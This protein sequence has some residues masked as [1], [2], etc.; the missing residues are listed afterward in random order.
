MQGGRRTTVNVLADAVLWSDLGIVPVSVSLLAQRL[1]YYLYSISKIC[2][3]S[4][5]NLSYS[6]LIRSDV[7]HA[8]RCVGFDFG[9]LHLLTCQPLPMDPSHCFELD[10][11]SG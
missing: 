2:N 4:A 9:L 8:I 3:Y 5:H 6:S 10:H 7:P 11:S 1:D